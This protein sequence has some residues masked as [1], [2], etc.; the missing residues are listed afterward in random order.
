MPKRKKNNQSAEKKESS[1]R[2][3]TTKEVNQSQFLLLPP[4]LVCAIFDFI[5]DNNRELCNFSNTCSLVYN[6]F[7]QHERSFLLR[8]R[9]HCLS[10]FAAVGNDKQSIK[11]AKRQ[12]QSTK[13][14]IEFEE[15]RLERKYK[16]LKKQKNWKYWLSQNQNYKNKY[17]DSHLTQDERQM[18][19]DRLFNLVTIDFLEE[20]DNYPALQYETRIAIDTKFRLYS[21]IST[22]QHSEEYETYL[23]ITITETGKELVILSRSIYNDA[24]TTIITQI[25]QELNLQFVSRNELQKLLLFALPWAWDLFQQLKSNN[26]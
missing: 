20:I 23:T 22:S 2:S 6:T 15:N 11:H 21:R 5:H 10:Q 7:L 4:E 17:P 8:F 25:G 1:K 13:N 14:M 12:M 26:V 19:Y 3:R 9:S 24:N 18:V 16:L